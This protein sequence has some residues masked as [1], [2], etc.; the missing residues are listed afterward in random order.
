M[1]VP[2]AVVGNVNLNCVF[3]KDK[4]NVWLLV[5]VTSH[6]ATKQTALF[7]NYKPMI[8]LILLI[9]NLNHLYQ[10]AMPIYMLEELEDKLYLLQRRLNVYADQIVME[11]D[12]S[13]RLQNN[14]FH[15][16]S[17]GI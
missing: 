16:P 17:E 2:S 6:T 13:N 11:G 7:E 15:S 12:K 8:P 14:L 1:P 4:K 5:N 3:F 9:I 10:S